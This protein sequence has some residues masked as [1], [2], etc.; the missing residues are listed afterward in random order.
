MCQHVVAQIESEHNRPA[1]LSAALR[2]LLETLNPT[3]NTN[4]GNPSYTAHHSH[5][6]HVANQYQAGNQ[7]GAQSSSASAAAAQSNA[8]GKAR[9]SSNS[10]QA[11]SSVVY[12]ERLSLEDRVA[13]A[14]T[15]LVSFVKL[16]PIYYM[17]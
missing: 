6:S 1:Y 13:F 14:C 17:P 16:S 3:T 4:T 15:F 5:S 7:K 8:T 10:T 12:D 11:Y 2:F 9:F